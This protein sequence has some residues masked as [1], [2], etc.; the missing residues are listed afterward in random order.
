MSQ[1]ETENV[2]EEGHDPEASNL[3]NSK[4]LAKDSINASLYK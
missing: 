3:I 2:R 4:I 1:F